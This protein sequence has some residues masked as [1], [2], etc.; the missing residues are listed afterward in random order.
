MPMLPVAMLVTEARWTLVLV[1]II[2]VMVLMLNPELLAAALVP[3]I[4]DMEFM[5]PEFMLPATPEA[6]DV[7]PIEFIPLLRLE[8]RPELELLVPLPADR[9]VEVTVSATSTPT[10]MPRNASFASAKLFGART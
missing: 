9:P 2:P 4:E 10:G 5:L 7:P 1:V 6:L 8:L 3:V